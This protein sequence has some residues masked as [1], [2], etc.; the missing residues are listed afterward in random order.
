[1]DSQRV[2]YKWKIIAWNVLRKEDKNFDQKTWTLQESQWF[3]S[4]KTCIKD[5]KSVTKNGYDVVDSWGIS[6]YLLKRTVMS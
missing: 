1:M 5:F 4:K 6:E 2:Q 3:D